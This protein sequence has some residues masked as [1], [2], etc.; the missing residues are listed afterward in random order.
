[1]PAPVSAARYRGSA[2]RADRF[3][4]RRSSRRT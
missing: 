2:R 3:F 4:C 1:V